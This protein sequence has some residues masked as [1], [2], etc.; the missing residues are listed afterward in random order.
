MTEIRMS[1]VKTTFMKI[2]CNNNFKILYK[3][4]TD[5]KDMLRNSEYITCYILMSTIFCCHYIC[6]NVY[7][8]AALKQQCALCITKKGPDMAQVRSCQLKHAFVSCILEAHFLC[9]LT[10]F[11]SFIIHHNTHKCFHTLLTPGKWKTE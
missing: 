8:P 11:F 4:Q 9:P 7:I 3:I 1:C 2:T 5:T 6:A 10:C